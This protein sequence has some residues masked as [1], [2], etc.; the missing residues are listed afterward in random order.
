MRQAACARQSH[1]YFLNGFRVS[2]EGAK[3]KKPSVPKA[4][5]DLRKSSK[6]ALKLFS[7]FLRGASCP[8]S[9]RFEC[10]GVNG[11]LSQL[12]LLSD[13]WELMSRKRCG[14]RRLGAVVWSR[15]PA[16]GCGWTVVVDLIWADLSLNPHPFKSERVRHPKAEF[17]SGLQQNVLPM[18]PIG[19]SMRRRK[20][21]SA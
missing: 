20:L 9:P 16:T 6:K 21:A 13:R 1:S 12:H 19:I 11:S 10:D 8:K 2:R 18:R 14:G 15:N 4:W 17:V 3:T 5:R 7:S